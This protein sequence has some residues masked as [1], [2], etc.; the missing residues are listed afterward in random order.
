[1]Y[2]L[3]L[4]IQ[5]WSDNTVHIKLQIT[6]GYLRGPCP[7]FQRQSNAYAVDAQ[8]FTRPSL[9]VLENDPHRNCESWYSAA[10]A[11]P[12]T[13]VRQFSKPPYRT[14]YLLESDQ[15]YMWDWRIAP[16]DVYTPAQQ[17]R[18]RYRILSPHNVLWQN[19]W[20]DSVVL[21]ERVLLQW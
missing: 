19:V 4:I 7:K 18:Q 17:E 21:E 6:I 10:M 13:S 14:R 11:E 3:S 20:W 5:S 15:W 2:A 12:W 16:P 9:Y 1:M 8:N